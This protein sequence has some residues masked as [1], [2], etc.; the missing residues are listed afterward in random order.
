MKLTDRR[1]DEWS[2]TVTVMDLGR[3]FLGLTG[4]MYFVFCRLYPCPPSHRGSV[5]PLLIISL[6]LTNT[7]SAVRACL[8]IWLERFRGT[9]K[10]DQ[11]GPLF[12]VWVVV[13][14]FRLSAPLS[15]SVHCIFVCDGRKGVGVHPPP[16]LAWATFSIMMESKAAVATLCVL[17]GY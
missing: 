17:C 13:I 10:E 3:R 1:H 11:R 7:V 15:W 4:P 14:R 8:S 6:L 9:Q 12:T 5:W 2:C 16:S